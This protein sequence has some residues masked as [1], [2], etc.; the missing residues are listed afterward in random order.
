MTTTRRS[1]PARSGT[2]ST[3]TRPTGPS[4]R[5]PTSGIFDR[6][7]AGPAAMPGEELAGAV[8]AAEVD[9]V[10]L[11]ADTLVALGLLTADGAGYGLLPVAAEY[12]VHRLTEVDGVPGTPLTRSA[13]G[14]AR[15]GGHRPGRRRRGPHRRRPGR[16]LPGARPCDGAHPAGGRGR[17][18]RRAGGSG[19]APGRREHRRP[20]RRLRRLGR[21]AA[22]GTAG[23][24]GRGGGPAGG[25]GHRHRGC[26]G[27]RWRAGP[28]SSR[29]TTCRRRCRWRRPTSSCS[30]TCCGPSRST[31]R[32]RCCVGRWSWPARRGPSSSPT[33][34]ARP[35]DGAGRR[36]RRRVRCRPSRAAA[37]AHDA[38]LHRRCRCERRRPAASGQPTAAPTSPQR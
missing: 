20:R 26:R 18:R 31:G 7:A 25:R 30:R 22:G 16:V 1:A 38:G 23:I 11:L 17:D 5:R 36:A 9:P 27:G 15:A 33:T 19:L 28:P 34:R 29:A 21:G 32:G 35:A 4:P 37:V 6:L 8:G 12:L 13:R 2:S 14:L 24:A 3:A 10:V